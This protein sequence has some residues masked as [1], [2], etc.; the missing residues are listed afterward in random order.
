MSY[1][2]SVS[3]QIYFNSEIKRFQVIFITQILTL[4]KSEELKMFV[5]DVEN[6]AGAPLISNEPEPESSLDK[7]KFQ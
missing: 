5:W 6:I 7:I 2:R 1:N 3:F 4:I